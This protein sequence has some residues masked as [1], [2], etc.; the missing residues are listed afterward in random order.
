M[1]TVSSHIL[2]SVIGDHAGGI[3]VECYRLSDAGARQQVF[4]AIANEEGRIAET[5]SVD[6]AQQDARYELVFHTA[7]YFKDKSIPAAEKQ[8]MAEVVVRINM[9]DAEARYHIPLVLSPHSYT[10]W[11]SG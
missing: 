11:W 9:P 2:D 7:A 4:N 3:R 8:I 10:I 5:V 6:S 1:A